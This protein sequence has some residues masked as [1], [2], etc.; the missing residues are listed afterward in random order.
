MLV[1][2]KPGRE[3][4]KSVEKRLENDGSL[5]V[6]LLA[7]GSLRVI[8]S[9]GTGCARERSSSHYEQAGSFTTKLSDELAASIFLSTPKL[10]GIV[11]TGS[12]P[13]RR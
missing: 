6:N 8:G 2:P 7:A 4:P 11:P 9:A 5:V 13:D 10:F 3:I 12:D 1:F